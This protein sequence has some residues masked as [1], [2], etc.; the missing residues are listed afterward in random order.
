M[1]SIKVPKDVMYILDTLNQNGYEAYVVGGCVRDCLLGKRPNDWDIATSAMPQQVKALFPRTYDTG[2][3]HGTVT[4]IINAKS[5][6]I[7]T[8][9]LDGKYQDHRRPS[10]IQFTQNIVKDLKRRDFTMNAIAY[11]PYKGLADPFDGRKDIKAKLIKCVGL[12]GERFREDALRMLRAVRF[13]SQLNFAIEQNTLQAICENGKLITKVSQ[14]RIREELN[15]VLLS[16]Y[17]E[18]LLRMH[19]TKIL[20]YILP[21]F[22]RCLHTPQNHPYHAYDVGNHSIA[23]VRNIE[24]E[25]VLRWTMLLHDIG[26]PV[27]RTTDEQGIDHF[28]GHGQQSTILAK[29][30]LTRL[31]FDKKT[32]ENILGLI[33]WHDRPIHPTP[34]AVK[35]AV[36]VIGEG[37]FYDL[38][39]VK[40]ADIKAQNPA[41]KEKRL[42]DI[43]VI[44]DIFDDIQRSGQCISIKDLAVNGKDL[45]AIGVRQG[46]E[47]G[48]VLEKLLDIVIES[49]EK[50][51]RE[52]LT[53]LAKA[54]YERLYMGR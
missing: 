39:K 17:P 30:V 36:R 40:E 16:E 31:R 44:R 7:T 46:K 41:L 42:E 1:E 11:H 51:N 50:N 47:V 8:Y 21:E 27:C 35:K 22:E 19:E 4:V 13:S 18:K 26:K 12:A 33:K 20:A 32:T 15:K 6:E 28:Y 45:L 38:L 3:K 34:R 49:P 2:I 10:E 25:L 29:K 23:A 53:A 54:F 37:I 14:E 5:F 9:R 43:K 24:K 48:M 52:T